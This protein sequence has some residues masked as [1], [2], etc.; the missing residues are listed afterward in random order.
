LRFGW[1]NKSRTKK[2]ENKSNPELKKGFDKMVE[3][4]F[5]CTRRKFN[6]LPNL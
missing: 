2:M 6:I 4:L 3:A 1:F 5:F